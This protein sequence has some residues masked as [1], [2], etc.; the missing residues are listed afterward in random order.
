VLEP[1]VVP[2]LVGDPGDPA[3][4]V[5]ALVERLRRAVGEGAHVTVPAAD[6]VPAADGVAL[7]DGRGLLV[8]PALAALPG[9]GSTGESGREEGLVGDVEAAGLVIGV[10]P[11]GLTALDQAFQGLRE[12]T[13][14]LSESG[15]GFAPWL[16]AL[17]LAGGACELVRR[18]ARAE[19]GTQAPGW[20]PGVANS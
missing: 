14:R 13:E 17:L 8:A 2:D 20:W 12:E 4:G 5:G 11:G 3:A 9:P 19:S 7:L 15:Y 18:R 16:F 6:A 1:E 10:P